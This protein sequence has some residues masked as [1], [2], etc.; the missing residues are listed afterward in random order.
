MD[1]L[2][3]AD[4][5][6]AQLTGDEGVAAKYGVTLTERLTKPWADAANAAEAWKSEMETQLGG[7]GSL[8]SL[9]GEDGVITAFA[10]GIGEQLSGS[11]DSAKGAAEGYSDF[12]TAPE[13]GTTF[14]NTLTGFGTQIQ[15]LVT[16][17]ENVE[18]AARKAHAEQ[19]RKVTVGGKDSGGDGDSGKQPAPANIGVVGAIGMATGSVEDLQEVLNTVFAAEIKVDGKY[20]SATKDAVENAQ[21]I[22]GVGADGYYG[23]ATRAAMEKYIKNTWLKQYGGSSM[24][25]Q[26]IKKMLGILPTSFYAKGTLGTSKNELAVVDEIGPELILRAN[27]E[28]GRLDY[29]TRGTSVMPADISANLVEWGKLNPNRMSLPNAM[30]NMNMISNAINKPELNF[31]VD[32]FLRCD[33]VSHDSLPELKQF[34]RT[35]MNNLIKQMNYAIKGKGG[36]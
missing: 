35:E 14:E 33:N 4:E 9:T 29:L 24:Y 15:G 34:V 7:S 26:A 18:E 11:W 3:N 25:G 21:Q 22:I 17:W 5:I 23:P 28:T 32:N 27:P 16:H 13:L 31:S 2:L 1:V 20:G 36:R 8:A 12:L 19:E 10:N 30:P 6:L